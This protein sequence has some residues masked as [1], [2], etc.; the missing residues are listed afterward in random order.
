MTELEKAYTFCRQVAHRLGPNFSIGFRFLPPSK[1]RAVYAI[2]AFCRFVDDAVDEGSRIKV[3]ER[4]DAW[5]EELE[6]CYEGTPKHPATVALADTV[7]NYPVPK[8]AFID[9]I[10]GCCQDLTKNRYENFHELM[11]YSD[12]VATTISTMSLSIFGFKDPVA[13]DRGR[14][15]ATAFQLTNILRDI[16]EDIRKDRVYL[17]ADE[18]RTFGVS[19][20]DIQSQRVMPEFRELMCFQVQRVRKYYHRAEALLEMVDP[21]VR[22]C[23]YL[24]GAVYY[25]VLER[26]EKED[27]RVFGHRIG[28][29]LVEKIRLVANA[30]VTK[31]PTWTTMSCQE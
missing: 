18:M 9:L 4:I 31:S 22:R 26:I 27:Y 15:L 3:Y 24:M 13:I 17:P 11:G 8:S 14:D 16:G 1:R 20:E 12:L 7:A 10:E 23:T 30:Y 2:Y 5:K 21:D 25:Q 29:T 6:R 28:L 19:V